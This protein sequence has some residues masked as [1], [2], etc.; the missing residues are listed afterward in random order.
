MNYWI[1]DIKQS[2]HDLLG[3]MVF[4]PIITIAFSAFIFIWF[5]NQLSAH[6]AKVSFHE[7]SRRMFFSLYA[8]ASCW[9]F[10]FGICFLL[11]APAQIYKSQSQALAALAKSQTVQNA[12]R[13]KFQSNLTSDYAEHTVKR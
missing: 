4:A 9:V 5:F 12:G 7:Q 13:N 6:S 11:V 8:A 10:I 1:L 2:G 3:V